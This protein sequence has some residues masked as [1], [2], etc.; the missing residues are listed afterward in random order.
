MSI[1][2]ISRTKLNWQAPDLINKMILATKLEEKNI[3]WSLKPRGDKV[4]FDYKH[5]LL[6]FVRDN[7]MEFLPFYPTDFSLPNSMTVPE[8]NNKNKE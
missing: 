2:N 4:F 3:V 6:V 7:M 8:P 5:K 1:R